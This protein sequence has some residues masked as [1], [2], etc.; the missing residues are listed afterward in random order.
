MS[1]ER[2]RLMDYVGGDRALVDIRP[3]DIRAWL[4]T[5]PGLDAGKR[6]D[7]LAAVSEVYRLAQR[8]GAVPAGYNPARITQQL[9]CP[10][11]QVGITELATVLASRR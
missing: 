10:G 8:E 3:R 4:K 11:D 5:L 2:A 6:R 1:V 7:H 9:A